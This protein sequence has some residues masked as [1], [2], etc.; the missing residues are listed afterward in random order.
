M[1]VNPTMPVEQQPCWP[2]LECQETVMRHWPDISAVSGD[3]VFD[4]KCSVW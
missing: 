4:I 3:S 1:H 2:F